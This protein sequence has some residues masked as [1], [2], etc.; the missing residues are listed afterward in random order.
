[1]TRTVTAT[2]A[3]NSLG[4]LVKWSNDNR[5]AVV[6]QQYGQPKAVLM[7]YDDFVEY[8]AAQEASRRRSTLGEIRLI[9][10]GI[11]ARNQEL[12]PDDSA[13]ELLREAGFAEEVIE[14]TI[15]FDKQ[16]T[17]ARQ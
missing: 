17:E 11:R 4:E 7:S 1:M 6:I 10:E 13:E 15:E 8:A 16:R 2:E 14:E 9:L 12:F 3:K 5:S